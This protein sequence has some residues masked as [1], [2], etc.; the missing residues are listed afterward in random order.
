MSI[1]EDIYYTL[2]GVMKDEYCVPGIENAFETGNECYRNYAAM[3]DAYERLCVRLGNVQWDD[4]VEIIIDSLLDNQ[5]ILCQKMF[6]YG[7][8]TPGG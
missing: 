2:L 3:L 8:T 6:E 1:A 5:K 4:D 7:Q